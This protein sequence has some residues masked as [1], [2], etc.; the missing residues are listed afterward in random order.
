MIHFCIYF[1]AFDKLKNE[2]WKCAVINCSCSFY[3]YPG[4]ALKFSR[5]TIRFFFTRH[6]SH[7]PFALPKNDLPPNSCGI[8]WTT[9]GTPIYYGTMVENGLSRASIF[10]QCSMSDML[11]IVSRCAVFRGESLLV[12][13]LGVVNLCCQWMC[14]GNFSAL[15]V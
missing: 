14:L 7:P 2:F 3:G 15:S 11:Q 5:H 1:T 10:K 9:C 4:M 12:G 13:P 8:L 6:S